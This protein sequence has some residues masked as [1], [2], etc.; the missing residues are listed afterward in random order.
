VDCAKRAAEARKRKNLERKL[1]KEQLIEKMNANDWD[2]VIQ[3]VIDRA[4]IT[5][6]GF[7]VLRDTLGEKPKETVDINGTPA[8][9]ILSG[10]SDI[11]D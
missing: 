10:E 5:D 9:V 11:K 4:K 7:E 8:V 3:G 2:E 6:K 1:I